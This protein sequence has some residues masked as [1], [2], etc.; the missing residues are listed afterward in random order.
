[1]R[2][3]FIISVLLLC[4]IALALSCR[5]RSGNTAPKV[6]FN[7]AV[8]NTPEGDPGL[9][10]PEKPGP[11]GLVA[12]LYHHHTRYTGPFFQ[13]TS[14]ARVDKYFTKPLADLIWKDS[15]TA[16]GA[17][18]AIE[19]DPVYA[20]QDTEIKDLEVGTAVI[21]GDSA[22]VPVTFLNF[23]AKQKVTFAL[24][25]V[26][27]N[28][29]IDDIKYPKGDSLMKWLTDTYPADAASTGKFEGRYQVGETT[30]TVT[31]VDTAFEVRWA[32]GKGVE[33]FFAKEGRTF[34]TPP[35]D[36]KSN[37]F[38]FA[39]DNYSSGMFYRADGEMFAVKRM[40]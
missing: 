15:T 28:W 10:P 4:S 38:V 9:A 5:S 30:C 23:E 33:T 18:G 29:R 13:T 37:Q 1:M 35:V 3:K 7:S 16:K 17:V 36:G 31:A 11:E 26:D 8:Q 34:E 24:K 40:K 19:A 14:R 12:D 2:I 20:A 22:T 25:M 27:G 21:T 32:K 6:V 39:D